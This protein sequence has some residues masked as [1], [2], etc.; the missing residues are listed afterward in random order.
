MPAADWR[1]E[2]RRRLAVAADVGLDKVSLI[3][4]TETIDGTVLRFDVQPEIPGAYE[5][6]RQKLAEKISKAFLTSIFGVPVTDVDTFLM[7]EQPPFG[8]PPRSTI[9]P[10][11]S[12]TSA[13]PVVPGVIVA[14]VVPIVLLL[15][16]VPLG[17]QLYKRR[18]KR[19]DSVT[20]IPGRDLIP[21]PPVP[22]GG[23]GGP[24]RL[25]SRTPA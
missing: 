3:S 25:P 20:V 21:P 2:F 15:I 5:A 10:P 16:L 24:T 22:G 14:I 1:T 11:S 6:L 12:P 7:T 19:I 18:K 17:Y 23:G 9:S 13:A 8:P 4:V